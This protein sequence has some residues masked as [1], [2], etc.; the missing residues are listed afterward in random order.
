MDE[1]I[2][3]AKNGDQMA[4]NEIFDSYK[5]LIRSIA[6]NFY[7]VGGDKDD[8]L[9]EG[10]VGLFYA[11]TNYDET[12]G[13][14][15][16]FVKLCVVRQIIDAV[17]KDN[18][19]KNKPLREHI[20]ISE[21]NITDESTPLEYVLKKEHIERIVQITNEKLTSTEKQVIKLFS[22]GYSY[23]DISEKLQITYKAVDGAMQRARKKLL[24]YL[25]KE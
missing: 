14:F 15:P 6:N 13:S 8:L 1:L 9:Q 23:D 2:Q 21:V 3:R 17:N 18:S 24:L 7:L 22:E 10:M 4:M 20:D 12:K 5:G 25:Y 11:V 19:D 16:S